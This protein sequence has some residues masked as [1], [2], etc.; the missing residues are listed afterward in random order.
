MIRPAPL[1]MLLAV[2]FQFTF[3]A[4]DHRAAGQSPEPSRPGAIGWRAPDGDAGGRYGD[5]AAQ[6]LSETAPA[7]APPITP[8]PLTGAA[9]PDQQT[10][11]QVTKGAGT[12]PNDHGQVWREYDITPYT[13]RVES[14]E[15]PEQAI[16][17]WILRETG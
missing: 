13:I 4:S 1:V 16:V 2:A 6:P 10:R 14:T 17:D 15:H 11:A 9:P 5:V 8:T 7:Q 3:V 12:L